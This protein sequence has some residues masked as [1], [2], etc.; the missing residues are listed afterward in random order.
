[1]QKRNLLSESLP[2]HLL[3]TST[4]IVDHHSI[5]KDTRGSMRPALGRLKQHLGPN[6]IAIVIDKDQ[7]LRL[8]YISG[9]S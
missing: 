8:L 3:Y 2:T 6:E 7:L 4:A 9:H 5:L 1:M